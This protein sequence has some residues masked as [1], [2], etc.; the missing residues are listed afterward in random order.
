V[1]SVRWGDVKES[2]VA[3]FLFSHTLRLKYSSGK[4]ETYW[5]IQRAPSRKFKLL[6]PAL[7]AGSQ[8]E[9]SPAGEMTS[10]CPDCFAALTPGVYQC[11]QCGLQFKNEKTLLWRAFL[12]PGGGYFYAGQTFLG[13]MDFLVTSLLLLGVVAG[14]L[15]VAGVLK[16]SPG[17]D[18]TAVFIVELILLAVEDLVTWWHSRRFIRE[19]I[20]TGEKRP[21]GVMAAGVGR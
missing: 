2:K 8:A 4:S 7:T 11:P 21:A 1:R 18:A 9:S 13:V 17:E 19:F 3:G 14:A 16:S 5:G 15:T 20:P 12:I 6:I 10:L